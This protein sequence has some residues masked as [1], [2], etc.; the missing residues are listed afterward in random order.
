MPRRADARTLLF[1]KIRASPP[2]FVHVTGVP[3]IAER[4]PEKE[5]VQGGDILLTLEAPPYG[6]LR[7]RLNTASELD[8]AAGRDGRMRVGIVSL[9]WTEKPPTALSE[10]SGQDYARIQAALPVTY[11]LY[12]REALA[13]LLLGRA[14]RA[15]RAE[16]WGELYASDHLGVRQIHGRRASLSA[17][18][19]L[20]NRDGALKLYYADDQLAEL[21]LFK[22]AGQA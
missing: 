8:L 10:E 11:E 4:E 18:V 15:V 7:A 17:P 14:K 9:N 19:D 1:E 13:A 12:E 22:F 5:G 6:R 3:Y 2:K 20:P 21:F 16:V